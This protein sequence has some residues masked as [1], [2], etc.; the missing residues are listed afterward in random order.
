MLFNCPRLS[1]PPPPPRVCPLAPLTGLV[2]KCNT[3]QIISPLTAIA[4]LPL[5]PIIQQNGGLLCYF[6]TAWIKIKASTA[7]AVEALILIDAFISAFGFR[8]P[9]TD[10][11][12]RGLCVGFVI[13]PAIG[14]LTDN[15]RPQ[16]FKSLQNQFS[17]GV[18]DGCLSVKGGGCQT[19][20][21]GGATH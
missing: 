10:V 18:C 19:R 1:S 12:A 3:A 2:L 4:R 14:S 5:H 17:T 13:P 8:R 6:K 15:N 9:G 16:K 7:E 20:G 21:G 11:R